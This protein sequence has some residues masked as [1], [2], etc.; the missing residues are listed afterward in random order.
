MLVF[1]LDLNLLPPD[2]CDLEGD[3]NLLLGEIVPCLVII[4]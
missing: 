1:R 4:S 3:I 2:N